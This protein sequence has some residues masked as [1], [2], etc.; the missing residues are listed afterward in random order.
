MRILFPN[1]THHLIPLIQSLTNNGCDVE[2][3]IPNYRSI[4][5]KLEK[6][7][8]PTY[9]AN[10]EN[11]Y[12]ELLNDLCN[13]N[14]YDY[15]FPNYFDNHALEVAVLNEKYNMPGIRINS[16]LN[17]LEKLSYYDKF[18]NL[19]IKHPKILKKI[20]CHENTKD[21]NFSNITYPCIAKPNNGTGSSGIRLIKD[22]KE[23]KLF[24]G[25]GK[26][27]ER[28][29]MLGRNS[30]CDYIIQEYI[31]GKVVCPMGHITNGDIKVDF[32]QEIIK[33][34]G[35]FFPERGLSMPVDLNLT[36]QKNIEKDIKEFCSSIGLDNTAWRCEVIITDTDY[37]FI[38]FGARIGGLNNQILLY[39]SGEENYAWKL[40]DSIFNKN[41]SVISC[42]QAAV[43][44]ELKLPY[45]KLS[46]FTYDSTLIDYIILPTE[47]VKIS[48]IDNDVFEN[49]FV[50]LTDT[51]VPNCIE[52]YKKFMNTLNFSIDQGDQ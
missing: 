36:V 48:K 32:Y 23:L 20:Y 22:E 31:E 42:N 27:A 51:S 49:G 5:D 37:Y 11:H 21:I 12:I 24:F 30:D 26:L 16:A 28:H 40:I 18:Q 8:H 6:I 17:L 4:E 34:E 2:F 33:S 9:R 38:D 13:K 15:I 7:S 39:Y 19:G 43:F 47:K 41:S 46:N 14:Y 35:P 3:L 52:K 1:P 50:I 25:P 44:Q 45:K 10:D 29:N